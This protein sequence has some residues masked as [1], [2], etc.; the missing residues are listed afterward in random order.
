MGRGPGQPDLPARN[1][2][3]GRADADAIAAALGGRV[4]G[5]IDLINAFQ[6]ETS[7][8]TEADLKAALETATNT[9]GVELAAPNQAVKPLDDSGE[10]WGTRISPAQDP[11]YA[12]SAG[13]GYKLIGVEKAWEYIRGSGMPLDPTQVGIVDTGLYPGHRRIRRRRDHHLHG[14]CGAARGPGAG[15]IQRRHQGE[16]PGGRPWDE[17]EHA[18]RRQRRQRRPHGHCRADGEGAHVVEHE[19]LR[20]PLRKSR[21][22]GQ[23]GP[24]RGDTGSQ[25]PGDPG[26]YGNSGTYSFSGLAAIMAQVK[27][28]STVINLSWGSKDYKTEDPEMVKVYR[29]VLRPARQGEAERRLRRRCRER[30]YRHERRPVLSPAGSARQMSSRSAM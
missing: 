13:D 30:R 4:V 24:C 22:G 18:H 9:A 1:T 12:G 19:P 2:G 29:D 7:G 26:K 16:G 5:Q 11:V 23:I 20:A 6:V 8:Q 3:K 27:A 25:Q 21:P 10:I 14:S 17:C 15:H 28:G